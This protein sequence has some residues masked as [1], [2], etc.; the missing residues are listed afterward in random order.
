MALTVTPCALDGERTREG[1]NGS[2]RA[3]VGGDFFE[4]DE[5][6][7]RRDVDDPA[8]AACEHGPAED[9]AGAEGAGDVGVHDGLPLVFGKVDG[10]GALDLA[11]AVDEDVDFTEGLEGGRAECFEAGAI[12]DV[13]WLT[14]RP[15]AGCFDGGCSLI[16]L[17]GATAGGDDVGACFC[18][19]NRHGETN[20]RGATHHYRGLPCQIK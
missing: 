16:D 1:S 18:E 4:T 12:G 5:G 2:L 8:I 17:L 19:A 3:G 10:G 20:A 6:I 13:G 14:Q 11:G 9:L 7:E 15:N